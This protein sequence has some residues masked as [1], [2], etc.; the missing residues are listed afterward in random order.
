MAFANTQVG[1]DTGTLKSVLNKFW[2]VRGSTAA[3]AER[4]LTKAGNFLLRE[5]KKKVPVEFG[6]LK[7]SGY[8]RKKGSGFKTVITVGYTAPY[9]AA[10]HEKVLMKLK[11]KPRRPSPP[12]I[13]RYWDPQGR[14]QAKFLEEPARTYQPDLRKIV[15]GEWVSGN[16]V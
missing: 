15:Y 5:S 2:R 7:A 9:A 14:A 4:A 6:K 12:H 3:K 16:F 11:G 10:V 8:V 1:V 13:G